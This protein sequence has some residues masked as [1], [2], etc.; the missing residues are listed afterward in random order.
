MSEP[1][2]DI[3]GETPDIE[4]LSLEIGGVTGAL[5]AIQPVKQRL[6]A[7]RLLIPVAAILVSLLLFGAFVSLFR[8]NPFSVYR[9]IYL[10]AFGSWFSWQN[11][12][13]RAAPLM[14]TALCTA[15]PA[16][17]GLVVIGGEGA[18]IIGALATVLSAAAIAGAG[19]EL[20]LMTMM[21]AAFAAGGVWVAIAGVLRYYR[22]VNETISSLLLSYIA[23]AVMNHLVT[24]PIRDL[25]VV[26]RPSSWH[27][28]V[29]NMLGNIP[30]MDVHWG[31]LFGIV[32]CIL[33]YVLMQR[34]VF[35]F[36]CRIVGGNMRAAKMA[37]LAVGR[38]ITIACF[39]GGGA[40]GL[41]GMVEVAAGEG[42]LSSSLVVGYGYTG[43]LIAFIARQNPIAVIPAAILLG[44]LRAS[45][46]L[47][48]R[49]HGLPDASVLVLEGIMFVVIL[50]SE[51]FYGRLT[52]L[53]KAG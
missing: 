39:I 29:Q 22:G 21:A 13:Q 44:G 46:G 6:S 19:H 33:C 36:S 8:I 53:Q 45:G 5:A 38:L 25:E 20:T 24:G 1:T 34:T 47:L 48:Q 4:G 17:L 18:L 12:L 28:G 10:G 43:I 23:I 15:L 7:E 35:G 40:A 52:L 3:R 14:L 50:V 51:S 49:R 31:F 32:T 2:G 37:G 42:R 27:I 41:A 11:T 30:G 26:D 16:R 9:T